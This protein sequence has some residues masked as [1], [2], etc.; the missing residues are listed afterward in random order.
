ML[1][2]RAPGGHCPNE[3]SRGDRCWET[4]LRGDTLSSARKFE[5]GKAG[6]PKDSTSSLVRCT[7]D[8]GHGLPAAA[9]GVGMRRPLALA[10]TSAMST[11]DDVNGR[12]PIRGLRGAR[13]RG[14]TTC[15]SEGRTDDVG[16]DVFH[17]KQAVSGYSGGDACK[18]RAGLAV[19]FGCVRA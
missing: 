9:L 7:E 19:K 8:G 18:P 5:R 6:P 1:R 17:N 2:A 11:P 10:C 13:P 3:L 15:I 12:D 4:G 16:F 14:G